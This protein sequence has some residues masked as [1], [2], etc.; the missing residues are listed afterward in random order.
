M[1]DNINPSLSVP[2]ASQR[3]V[4]WPAVG[5]GMPDLL[6]FKH[7]GITAENVVSQ[8]KDMLGP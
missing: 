8:A 1:P 6:G 5:H 3:L 7:F 4:V 2:V